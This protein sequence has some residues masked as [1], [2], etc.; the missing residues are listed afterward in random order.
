MLGSSV[1]RSRRIPHFHGKRT[2]PVDLSDQD[3]LPSQSA[4]TAWSS[5]LDRRTNYA[6]ESGMLH[7]LTGIAASASTGVYHARYSDTDLSLE[8]GGSIVTTERPNR[9]L[10]P[11]GQV[12]SERAIG[13]RSIVASK[14]GSASPG[15]TTGK[16]STSSKLTAKAHIHPDV[17]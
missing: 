1:Y 8:E 5:D 16:S 3:E 6:P 9:N 14:G 7:S 12:S 2:R 15:S 11:D 17:A 4:A 13:A 10:P